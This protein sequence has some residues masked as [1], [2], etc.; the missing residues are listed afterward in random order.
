[1]NNSIVEKTVSEC[2][3]FFG[4]SS[5]T[6][7]E[8]LACERVRFEAGESV[9][10]ERLGM[11]G[12]VLS[13]KFTIKSADGGRVLM[14][15]VGAGGFFGAATVFIG[16]NA[17]SSITATAKSEVL[18][19]PRKTLE[20]IFVRDGNV[21]VSYVRMLSGKIFF[22]NKKIISLSSA[23]A[24]VALAAYLC[25]SA[26]GADEIRLNCSSCAKKLGVGR[27]TLY[28]AIKMLEDD[29]VIL[30][31]DGKI[32]IKDAKKLASRRENI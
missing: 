6:V 18:F 3:L 27:T 1:M 5:E 9:S 14:N 15:S 19:V 30:Y 20:K 10:G 16:E 17:I 22:L 31:V 7:S 11:L 25:D 4:C 29:G 13:G 28:R 8:L 23:R 2:E 32:I 12:I 26:G 24:D 21:C